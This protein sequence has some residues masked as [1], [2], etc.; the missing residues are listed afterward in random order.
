MTKVI[1]FEN[2]NGVSVC[3]IAPE[4]LNPKSGTREFLR[5]T[6]VDFN[7]DDEMIAW[8]KKKD[9][10]ENV[11]HLILDHTELPADTSYSEAW[12]ISG[13]GIT[14]NMDKAKVVHMMKL[15]FMK[16]AKFQSLG[17][18]TVPHPKLL[19]VMADDTLTSLGNCLDGYS[20]DGAKTVDDLAK[21]IPDMLK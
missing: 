17:F 18:L 6:G 16:L 12:E 20:L 14:V 8:V 13:N 7:S 3:N 19:E 9:I 11:N 5:S 21:M 10:P 2:G 15:Q 4:M 1:A